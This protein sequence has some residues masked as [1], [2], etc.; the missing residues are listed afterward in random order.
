MNNSRASAPWATVV[1]VAYNSGGL[2]Q[3]CVDGLADQSMAEF[4]AIIVDNAST[5]GSV[6][7]LRLPDDRFCIVPAGENLGFAGGC[8]RGLRASR[9][10]WI[11]TLNPDAVPAPHWLTALRRATE[12]HPDVVM[13]GSTQ[14]DAGDPGRLDGCGDA[15][16]FLGIPWRAGHGHPVAALPPEGEV[17]SPCAAAALYRRDVLQTVGGFDDAFFCYCEDVDLAFRIRLEG[18]QCIQV[19]DAVVSH[20]GSAVSGKR[21]AFAIYHG[22]RNGVWVMVK[23]LPL[24]LL[25]PLLPLHLACMGWSLWRRRGS[26][27]FPAMA[28]GLRAAF[29]GLGPVLKARHEIQRRRTVSARAVAGMLCWSI[30]KLRRADPDVGTFA[31]AKDGDLE[32]R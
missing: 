3:A 17:F 31:A 1:I 22:A 21:S 12:R 25:A 30:D 4:D 7:G 5:D 9:A 18:G 11:A 2:L 24:V 26:D 13:F 10:P 8:N 28:A 23:N 16:S 32:P 15:Y 14:L 27:A 6:R 29:A 20:V 19:P